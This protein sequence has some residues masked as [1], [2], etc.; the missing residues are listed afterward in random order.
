MGTT[1]IAI[2]QESYCGKSLFIYTYINKLVSVVPVNVWDNVFNHLL[3]RV[4][5]T[6]QNLNQSR[7]THRKEGLEDPFD[8]GGH[9]R[10]LLLHIPHSYSTICYYSRSVT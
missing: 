7:M 10:H 6:R 3:M 5:M 8:F 9:L 4:N 1:R 2:N